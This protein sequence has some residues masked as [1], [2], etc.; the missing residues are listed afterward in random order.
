MRHFLDFEKP[1]A[2]LESKVEELRHLSDGGDINIGEEVGKLEAKADRLLRQ[3]YAK[4]SPW[5]KVQ[6]ARHPERPH[7]SDYIDGLITDWTP[8]A[9]D[10][11]FAEDRAV[12]GGLGR[13]RGRSVVV[14]GTEKGADTESRV[15]HN[16]GM[17]RPEGYRKAMRLM[18]MADRFQLPLLTFVDTA[19]AYPGIDAEARGQAE[20]I[21]RSIER[22]LRIE[23][24]F[25]AA[26]IGE[27]GS[28]GAIALAAANAVVML[29]HAVYSVI[30]PEGCSSILW[31]SAENAQDAAEALRLTAQD[32][33]RLGVIDTIVPE[34][35]G[36]AHRRRIE[37][38]AAIGDALDAALKPLLSLDGRA[39]RAQRREKFL[40]M[41]KKGL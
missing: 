26:V 30:S 8:L 35:L 37:T 40:E 38:V 28:G 14:I 3:T 19:G 25:I 7:S 27:G 11:S 32:L 33:H 15:V 39:L 34:P 24:P 20:A 2:E 6:V 12:L 31:R 36:G 41:G 4:L 22:C 29:E 16:F 1:I 5:Q 13:F 10:R 23:V 18:E 17:A 21:A 9:G